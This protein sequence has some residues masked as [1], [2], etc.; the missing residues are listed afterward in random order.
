MATVMIL[1]RPRGDTSPP[2]SPC[3]GQVLH[4]ACSYIR[5]R[6]EWCGLCR[7]RSGRIGWVN[8][9]GAARKTHANFKRRP[10]SCANPQA[11][12][13]HVSAWSVALDDDDPVTRRSLRS[14]RAA[15]S[16]V[17]CN[18]RAWGV[19]SGRHRRSFGH[20]KV[21]VCGAAPPAQE[22]VHGRRSRLHC[23][24]GFMATASWAPVCPPTF[25]DSIL[26]PRYSIPC[27]S[28]AS[29]RRRQRLAREARTTGEGTSVL[30]IR[31]PRPDTAR[32]RSCAGST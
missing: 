25:D 19:Q 24:H 15:S 7:L 11:V 8:G 14:R 6:S 16:P 23:R 18:R 4:Q 21:I 22:A 17:R 26:R 30:T 13:V 9:L 20:G 12:L 27:V 2:L 32:C 31:N 3:A 29:D 28:A 1:S 5:I 10:S